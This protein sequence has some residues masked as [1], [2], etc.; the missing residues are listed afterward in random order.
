MNINSKRQPGQRGQ[1]RPASHHFDMS[2]SVEAPP[3]LMQSLQPP[4]Q[5]AVR[6][7]LREHLER[8]RA[9]ADDA[10]RSRP[11]NHDQVIHTRIM[12]WVGCMS[13]EQRNRRFTL[14]EV[15]RLAGLVGKR[16]GNA[17]HHEVARA[18]RSIGFVTG[19][20][21]SSAG[22]NRR[23]WKLADARGS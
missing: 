23:F 8:L 21:W 11:L 13:P 14:I 10:L 5:I 1:R 15:E 20:D 18:L 4:T 19:R 3:K 17:A 6:A 12:A 9:E 16:G 7:P 2:I 22:R